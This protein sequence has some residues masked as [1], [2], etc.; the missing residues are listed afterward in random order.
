MLIGTPLNTSALFQMEITFVPQW[1]LESL[2]AR[3]DQRIHLNSALSALLLLCA[4]PLLAMA[5]HFC[6]AQ[7]LLHIP[8]PGC[9]I[10]RSLLALA[11]MNLSESLAQNPAG[12]SFALM[13]AFQIFARPVAIFIPRASKSVSAAGQLLSAVTVFALFAVW[14]DRVL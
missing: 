14:I 7:T 11:R 12:I 3:E 6:L 2:C 13:L 5:P 8:C 9:G 1:I 4:L 10:T